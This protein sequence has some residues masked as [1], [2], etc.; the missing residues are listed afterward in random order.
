MILVVVNSSGWDDVKQAFF[1]RE[2]FA[3]AFPDILRAFW[4]NVK[5]FLIAEVFIL[6]FAL[7]VAVLRGLP[8]PVN[9]QVALTVEK[10]NAQRAVGQAGGVMLG[11]ANRDSRGGRA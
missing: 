7:A 3:S 2:E 9:A 6:V 5:I 10:P 8:G 11:V 4:I 1:S